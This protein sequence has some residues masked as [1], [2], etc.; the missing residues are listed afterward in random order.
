MPG[1]SH[2]WR[3]L[4]GYRP[5]VAKSWTGLRDFTFTFAFCTTKETSNKINSQHAKL[6]KI[7]ASHISNKVVT[8][9]IYEK[10]IELN[11]KQNQ[12]SF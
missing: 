3:S 5:W 8:S 7:F 2:G 9:K 10:C 1:K 4:I 11:I 6:E 12:S